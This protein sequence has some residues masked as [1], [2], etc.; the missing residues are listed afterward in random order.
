MLRYISDIWW[1]KIH[2]EVVTTAK[3]CDQCN[4]AGK[5]I[6]PLLKQKQFGKIPKSEN[7]NNEM[8]LDFAGLFQIA[9]HGKKHLLVAVDHFSAWLDALFLHKVTTKNVFE[10]LQKYIS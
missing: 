7:L 1:P 6:K 10:F 4:L 8:A 3:C 5:N 2:H 9:E